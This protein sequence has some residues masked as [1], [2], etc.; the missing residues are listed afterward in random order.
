MNALSIVN[1]VISLVSYKMHKAR[2]DVVTACVKSL[3]NGSA[4]TV[5]SIGRGISTKAFEKHRIKRADRLLSNPHLLS[6]TPFIYASICQ[7]FCSSTSRPVISIDWSDLDD[8][9]A[10]FLLRAAISLKGRPVTLY[11]EVHCNKTKEKPATHK[12]FLKT[13]HTI[14][15]SHCRPIIV[16]DAGYKSPWFREVLALGWDIVGRVRKPH[17]YSLDS[18]NTWQC[19]RN[20]YAKATCRPKRFDN[21][22]I[23]RSNP[24]ACTLVLFKQKS[25]GRHASNPDGTRKASKRS[26]V[27]A[28]G[29][30]DPWLLAT[31]LA[32]H[33][34]LSKQVV[35]IYR[36][37]MQ[38][39][40]GFRD[41]KSTKFGLGYEQNKSVKKQRLT[42]LVLLTTL[43]SLVAILLGMVLVSSNKH[44]RFQAN[45]E[46]RSVLSFH[47]LGLRAVACRIRFTMRQWKAALKWYSSIVDG[48]WTAGTWN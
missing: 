6:E 13:L 44:R 20:L 19:I 42:I 22:Q 29:A 46:T 17:F 30:K 8:R 41:M 21:S 36:Q 3:L 14:L 40:E 34:S 4:A 28:Q 16:T 47:Y 43:A 48:A 5:T 45:T 35:A 39:E 27:H 9:K 31:S 37:R 24:F 15:P 18:G 2:R 11:Q 32:T 23:V 12:A 26:K 25:K 7:L 33:R 10:H 1:N 38:I